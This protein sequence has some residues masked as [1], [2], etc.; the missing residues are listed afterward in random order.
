M[1]QNPRS[2]ANRKQAKTVLHLPVHR[3]Q[4]TEKYSR[5]R[6]DPSRRS[7]GYLMTFAR[8]RTMIFPLL[9]LLWPSFARAQDSVASLVE[10]TFRNEAANR[11]VP[12]H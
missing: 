5:E 9:L 8:L 11:R 3:H 4:S 10:K 2:K 1:K 6:V 12:N 7:R